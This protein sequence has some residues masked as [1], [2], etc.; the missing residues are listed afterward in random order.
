MQEPAV[1]GRLRRNTGLYRRIVRV[2]N[3]GYLLAIG[4]MLAGLLIGVI[5]GDHVARQT[6]QIRDILPGVARLQAQ[7]IVELGILVLL[8][9]PAVYVVVALLTFVRDRDKL[10][11]G[12]CLALL[13]ILS[14]SVGIS[15]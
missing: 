14:L 13:G 5:T 4:L 3:V 6:D 15:L 12:V 1:P 8:A 10:F 9:T 7:D 2:M 11:I